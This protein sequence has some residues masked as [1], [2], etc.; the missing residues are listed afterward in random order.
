MTTPG[1]EF[2]RFAMGCLFG[3]ALGLVYGF[4]SPLRP[5]HTKLTDSLFLLALFWAWLYQ[6]FGVCRGDLRLGY[7]SALA[8]GAFG[9]ELTLG[10]TLRPLF[11]RFWGLMGNTGR[12]LC[13]KICNFFKILLFEY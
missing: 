9:W 5:K 10:K 3:L 11:A 12:Y 13:K 7:Y 1:L 2:Y 8:V 6:G 4:L